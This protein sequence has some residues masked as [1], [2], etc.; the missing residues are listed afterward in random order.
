MNNMLRNMVTKKGAG[1][2]IT[3][4]SHVAANMYQ[5][6]QMVNEPDYIKYD[7]MLLETPPPICPI[8]N[9]MVSKME[10]NFTYPPLMC[11]F[12][13]AQMNSKKNTLINNYSKD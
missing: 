2:V 8:C 9:K 3:R 6:G 12:T 13:F 10:C 7:V 1:T 5:H 11:P 4:S